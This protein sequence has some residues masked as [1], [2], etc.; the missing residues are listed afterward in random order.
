MERRRGGCKKGEWG[1]VQQRVRHSWGNRKTQ[2]SADYYRIKQ[3]G[4]F[5][6][7]AKGPYGGN[8]GKLNKNPTRINAATC[9]EVYKT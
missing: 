3:F 7:N 2:D 5:S 6:P 1:I 4:K 8:G 9:G